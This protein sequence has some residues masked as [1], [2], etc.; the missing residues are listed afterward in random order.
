M[1]HSS[2]GKGMFCSMCI[3]GKTLERYNCVIV[4]KCYIVDISMCNMV[5]YCT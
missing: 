2:L 1:E 5:N 4:T 3:K